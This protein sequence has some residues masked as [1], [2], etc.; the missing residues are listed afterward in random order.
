MAKAQETRPVLIDPVDG[1]C[2]ICE[3]YKK[4]GKK[5]EHLCDKCGKP[6][7]GHDENMG[8]NGYQSVKPTHFHLVP[9]EGLGGRRAVFAEVCKKCYD[10]ERQA[11]YPSEKGVSRT[12]A[13]K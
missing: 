10:K 7:K 13:T 1:P 8:E 11:V 3:G 12:P 9:V 6:V 2:P 5:G 4:R